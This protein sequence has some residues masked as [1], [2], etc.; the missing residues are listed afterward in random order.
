MGRARVQSHGEKVEQEH[1]NEA[2]YSSATSPDKINKYA[3]HNAKKMVCSPAH[4]ATRYPGLLGQLT[5]KQESLKENEK[6]GGL[7]LARWHPA[8]EM[9]SEWSTSH[10]NDPTEQS[11]R[12]ATHC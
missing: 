12:T 5:L 6:K 2:V 9:W 10:S 11:P 4:L 7:L 3:N 1:T 8:R